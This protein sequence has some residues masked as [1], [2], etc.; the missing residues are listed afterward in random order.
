MGG[1]THLWNLS[2][3]FAGFFASDSL[4]LEILMFVIIESIIIGNIVGIPFEYY[5]TF[6]VE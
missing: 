2:K 5:K 3:Y 1:F 6:V 4:F